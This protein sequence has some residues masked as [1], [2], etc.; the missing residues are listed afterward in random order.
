MDKSTQ[1]K[2]EKLQSLEHTHQHILMQ[3]QAI[4]KQLLEIE[5]ALE[6]LSKKPKQV[7]KIVGAVMIES[8]FEELQK[9]L[10]G[11]KEIAD[12]KIRSIEKQEERIREDSRK[13]QEEVLRV[14]KKNE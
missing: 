3:K 7:F 5:S 13:I 9:D 14:I 11:K 1:E 12:I 4:Q 2:I 8:D 10:N 6:N